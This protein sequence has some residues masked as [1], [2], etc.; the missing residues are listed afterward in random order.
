M[1]FLSIV[2]Y[3]MIVL[4]VAS[5]TSVL[6]INIYVNTIK[7]NRELRSVIEKKEDE[8]IKQ[9]REINDLWKEK[10]KWA[11]EVARLKRRNR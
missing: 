6:W 8:I 11:L 1:M 9:N 2:K 4:I 10:N 3:T 7:E 5:I